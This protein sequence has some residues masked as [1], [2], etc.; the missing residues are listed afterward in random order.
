MKA[1]TGALAVALF[2][3]YAKRCDGT[4]GESWINCAARRDSLQLYR[5]LRRQLT[6]LNDGQPR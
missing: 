4:L 6:L 1:L 5:P 2:F 3:T